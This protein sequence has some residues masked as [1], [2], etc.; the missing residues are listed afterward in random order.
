MKSF[1]RVAAILLAL[2]MTVAFAACSGQNNGDSEAKTEVVMGTNAAFPPF[3]YVDDNGDFDG[4]DVALSKEIAAKM[5]AD[6]KVLDMEFNSL[7]SAIETDQVDFVAAGMT[8]NED[9][10]KSVDFSE[11]YFDASQVIIVMSDEEEIKTG[12]DLAN[13]KIGVQEATTG[14]IYCTD[15]IEGAEISRFKKGVDAVIDLI[16]GRVDAVVIDALPA[17]EFVKMNDGKIKILDEPL[18]EEKYAIAVKKGD[19]EMLETING[20]IAE[21]KEN[22][23]YDEMYKNYVEANAGAETAEPELEPETEGEDTAE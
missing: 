23:K 21:L 3:E 4:F 10:L 11:P 1:K 22:G 8:V 12:A 15:N 18:T 17:A 9:R 2:V 6:L 19:T 5:G 16:N 7:I 20:V 13:K 14:D